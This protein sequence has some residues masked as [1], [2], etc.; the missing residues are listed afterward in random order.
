[1]NK[2]D[3]MTLDQM[4]QALRRGKGRKREKYILSINDK[5]V[6]LLIAKFG[7]ETIADI[8][9]T[10][11]RIDDDAFNRWIAP[12]LKGR[13]GPVVVCQGSD[14]RLWTGRDD[15]GG[16]HSAAVLGP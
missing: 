4:Q 14:R 5:A 16:K 2:G 11:A 12:I 13:G 3:P 8:T 1:M 15:S 10:D 7:D 6:V 9:E